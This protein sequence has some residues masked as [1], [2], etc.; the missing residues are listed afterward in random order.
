MAKSEIGSFLKHRREELGKSIK[1]VAKETEFS[2]IYIQKIEGGLKRVSLRS[3]Y[4]IADV[5]EVEAKELIEQIM[6]DILDR[7]LGR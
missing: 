6:D 1:E 2:S 3:V 5:Y 4:K 7:K